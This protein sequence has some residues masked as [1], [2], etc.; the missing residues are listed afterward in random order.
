M[1]QL[2]ATLI[3]AE[4]LAFARAE[5]EWFRT[6]RISLLGVDVCMLDDADSRRLG[7]RALQVQATR[8]AK[9][10]ADL[11]DHARAGWRRSPPSA[12]PS[13]IGLR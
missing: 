9:A 2:P 1:K 3:E 11:V 5:F 10:M 12:A 6:N 8:S 13:I 7:V 4:A